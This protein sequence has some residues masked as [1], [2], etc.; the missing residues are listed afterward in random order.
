MCAVVSSRYA[1][2]SL[3]VSASEASVGSVSASASCSALS[4]DRSSLC[5]NA[6]TRGMG[7]VERISVP[8]QPM[9]TAATV[10]VEAGH[11]VATLA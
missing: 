2:A 7:V 6:S 1:V 3:N 8:D 9:H 10:V 4:Q 11:A 5:I